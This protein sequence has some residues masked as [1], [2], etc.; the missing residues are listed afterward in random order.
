MKKQQQ[1]QQQQQNKKKTNVSH[2]KQGKENFL[3]RRF[4]QLNQEIYLQSAYATV[5]QK[6]NVDKKYSRTSTTVTSLG[7]RKLLE[8]WVV[9]TTEG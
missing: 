6:F 2:Y 3:L 1:Q 9:R 7:P 5:L 4:F 8:I